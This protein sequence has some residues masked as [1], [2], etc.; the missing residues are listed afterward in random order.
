MMLQRLCGVGWVPP[1]GSVPR[2]ATPL[3]RCFP[4]GSSSTLDIDTAVL[5]EPETMNGYD[6]RGASQSLI[7]I[8]HDIIAED[9]Q[10]QAS[11]CCQPSN[12]V[13]RYARQQ[14][15]SKLTCLFAAQHVM[16]LQHCTQGGRLD[17][18][19][20]ERICSANTSIEILDRLF[21]EY[22]DRTVFGYC[23]PGETGYST[24]TFRQIWDRVKV[25][26]LPS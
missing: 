9:P 12:P 5:R 8:P 21:K 10:L 2:A 13:T 3:L 7:S 23:K 6:H 19:A 18:S 17:T 15:T 4:G 20:V 24:I 14:R 1:A 26:F 16:T 22:A 25:P 11:P